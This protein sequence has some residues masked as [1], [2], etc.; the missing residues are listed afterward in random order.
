MDA[1]RGCHVARTARKPTPAVGG[2]T[3]GTGHRTRLTIHPQRSGVVQHLHV[4]EVSQRLKRGDKEDRS[5]HRLA[6][7]VPGPAHRFSQSPRMQVV[8]QEKFEVGFP[9]EV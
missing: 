4:V 9:Q 7:R 6:S 1:R 8:H 5:T 3:L 2:A